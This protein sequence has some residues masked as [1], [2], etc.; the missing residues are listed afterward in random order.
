MNNALVT[1]C[2]LL[3]LIGCS[4]SERD[5]TGRPPLEPPVA[6]PLPLDSYWEMKQYLVDLVA[7]EDEAERDAGL[8]ALWDSLR[9]HEL[10]PFV[11]GDSVAFLYRGTAGSVVFTGDF[12]GWDPS[13]PRAVELED[14]SIWVQEEVFP[15]DARLDYKIVLDGSSWILDPENPRVQRSGFGDNSELRMPGYV[16]S[17]WVER[18]DGVPAGTLTPG[19]LASAALGYV[20]NYQVYA[21]AGYEGLDDLPVIY[22]TDGHEYADPL[23]GSLVEVLDNLIAEDLLRP[24]MAVFIDP[25]V[26][27]Q[28]LRAEQYVLNP[29]FVA[30]VVEELVPIIDLNWHTSPART[31]R[32]IL[33]TSLGGL[34]SAWFAL[35]AEATF[36]KIGIQSPA[37]QAGDGA[38]IGMYE[39]APRLDVDIFI[40]WGTFYDAGPTTL[41]FQAILDD[42]GYEYEHMLVN[43]GHSWGNWRA[44][45]DDALLAFWPAR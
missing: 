43:E 36:G 8:N 17:P 29:D 27:G 13:E 4:D 34:N 35:Q 20:V 44:L 3:L 15:S 5:T 33:G 12:D 32:G 24:V 19:S 1:L 37:F 25:R 31:D 42:K 14:T 28:N 22:V 9:V 11:A 38:I 2:A 41:Q 21:P 18:R 40:S 10:I 45:L 16:P 6:D 26:N 39:D 30:F 7:L 23:M